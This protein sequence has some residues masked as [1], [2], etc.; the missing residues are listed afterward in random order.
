MLQ[1][2][3]ICIIHY[4]YNAIAAVVYFNPQ[5]ILVSFCINLRCFQ[6]RDIWLELPSAC[7][8]AMLRIS[9]NTGTCGLPDMYALGPVSLG[10]WAYISGK[11]PV[12]I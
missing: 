6:L 5:S 3:Y 12:P 1:S 4:K 2:K 9:C 10:L 8:R 7:Q 11:S